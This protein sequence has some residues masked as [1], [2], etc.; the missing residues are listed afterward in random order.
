MER[1]R[2]ERGHGGGRI[3]VKGMTEGRRGGKRG[4]GKGKIDIYIFQNKS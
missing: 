1:N 4:N 2:G 3:E